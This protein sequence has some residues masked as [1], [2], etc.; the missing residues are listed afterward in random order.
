MSSSQ[1]LKQKSHRKR[2]NNGLSNDG[3]LDRCQGSRRHAGPDQHGRPIQRPQVHLRIPRDHPQI[4]AFQAPQQ[5]RQGSMH[6][7]T[8]NIAVLLFQ[9]ILPSCNM[10]VTKACYRCTQVWPIEGK[11]KFETLSYLPP[12]TFEQL[13]KQIEYLIRSKWIPCLEFSKVSIFQSR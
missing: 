6:A 8:Y 4:H 3:L 1:V 11:K 7:G 5:R 10:Y 9:S 13:V 12:L 2:D